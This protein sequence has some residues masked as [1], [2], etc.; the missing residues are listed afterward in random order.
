MIRTAIISSL[1]ILLL[2]ASVA[3]A[4]RENHF[5]KIQW[6]YAHQH[7]SQVGTGLE[8]QIFDDYSITKQA[9]TLGSYLWFKEH[10]GV[11]DKTKELDQ[12]LAQ[13]LLIYATNQANTLNKFD[14]GYL[15]NLLAQTY[16]VQRI[17]PKAAYYFNKGIDVEYPDACNNLGVMWEQ[18]ADFK[19]AEQTYLHCLSRSKEFATA[20]L[21]LNLGTI[22]YNGLGQ[23]ASDKKLGALYWQKSYDLFPFDADI[24]YNLGVY[25]L[26][27]TKN[28]AQARYHFAYCA[29]KDLQCVAALSNKALI[30]K[31][32]NKPYLQ[33][34]LTLQE[35]FQ[36]EHLLS[37]RLKHAFDGNIYFDVTTKHNLIF[38]MQKSQVEQVTSVSIS[39][40]K[41]HAERAVNMLNRLIYIDMFSDLNTKT[42]TLKHAI[43]S[44]KNYTFH[45]LAQMHQ[46]KFEADK[47]HYSIT[48]N[49]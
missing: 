34:I 45:Y 33:D 20:L 42:L 46:L 13:Q 17:T 26:N 18:Q 30:G 23:V 14:Q 28:Y 44:N 3:F 29:Y 24:N 31:Y 6:Q 2:S 22:Y 47:L 32:A 41:A 27:Q 12:K 48:F 10:K 35:Q 21:Y 36:R 1:L 5:D 40:E 25:H 16:Q 7:F 49:D 43:N 39:F 38:T 11:T 15:F 4:E 8:I 19:K 9:L 37:D